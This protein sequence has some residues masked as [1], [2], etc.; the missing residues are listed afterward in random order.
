LRH[1]NKCGKTITVKVKYEDFQQVTKRHTLN[2]YI[3]TY[4]DIIDN[5]NLL[6]EK[7]KNKDKQIRLI[8]VSISN[9]QDLKEEIYD[10]ISLLDQL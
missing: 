8:G 2:S 10:N 5:T 9:L 6:I 7:I 1:I 4:K 3:Y